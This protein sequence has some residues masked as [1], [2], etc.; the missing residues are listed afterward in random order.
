M[1][2]LTLLTITLATIVVVIYFIRNFLSIS[3]DEQIQK[4]KEWLLYAVAAAEK[5]LGAGT[6]QLKLAYVY[7]KFITKFSFLV[8]TISFEKF[9]EMVDEVLEQFKEILESN[10]NIEDYIKKD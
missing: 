9:S 1:S 3:S 10:E 5:E 8:S 7:D 4:V 6:G 2:N